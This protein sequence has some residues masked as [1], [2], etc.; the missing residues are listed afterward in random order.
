[1]WRFVE[2]AREQYSWHK[3]WCQNCCWM[4]S[5]QFF[6]GFSYI[7]LTLD[8]L[9]M[10][11]VLYCRNTEVGDLDLKITSSQG[12]A[13]SKCWQRRNRF[14]DLCELFYSTLL[15]STLLYSTLLYSTL[16]Y[17][18]LLY[19][20]LLYSTLLTSSLLYSTLLYPS[21]P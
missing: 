9:N 12:R 10:F 3:S 4:Y 13:Y 16:L 1:M 7:F 6:H 18:T 19:S 2:D 15:Y 5:I 20:T 8:S 21:T 17:S 14:K 11:K